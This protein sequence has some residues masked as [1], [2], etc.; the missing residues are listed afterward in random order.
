MHCLLFLT[1]YDDI[2]IHKSN[3]DGLPIELPDDTDCL[4]A[5][6]NIIANRYAPTIRHMADGRR[7]SI[8]DLGRGIE[9]RADLIISPFYD[10]DLNTGNNWNNLDEP[11]YTDFPTVDT[12]ALDPY[13]YYSVVWL[14]NYWVV[15]YGFYHARDWA[16]E[17][18]GISAIVCDA[19][20]HENDY[21]GA[22]FMISRESKEVVS[23]HSTAHFEFLS[24]TDL[25]ETPT[26]FIDDRTHAV[27]LNLF[28]GLCIDYGRE[29]TPIGPSV[30]NCDDCKGFFDPE[31]EVVYEPLPENDPLAEP[32]V[33]TELV[34]LGDQ[35][36]RYLLM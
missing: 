36:R 4:E 35:I 16:P 5:A 20:S 24:Y 2:Y 7:H 3:M 32:F 31:F 1:G 18:S 22:I 17:S 11:A 6:N 10:G 25:N 14:E 8:D 9:G 13:V 19:D 27:E 34:N 33:D 30:N 26:V 29:G 12:D 15:T 23:A 28:S 21:E